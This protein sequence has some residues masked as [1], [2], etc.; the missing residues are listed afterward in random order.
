MLLARAKV[1][2]EGK[3]VT[4]HAYG[5]VYIDS[6]PLADATGPQTLLADTLDGEPLPAEH[7]GP[8]RLVILR[9]SATRTS[10]GWTGSR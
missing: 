2:P 6:L 3:F 10:S 1:R 9:S 5:G 8:V 7:G 4:F